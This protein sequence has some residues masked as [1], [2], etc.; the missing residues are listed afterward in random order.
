MRYLTLALLLVFV[1]GVANAQN[2]EFDPNRIREIIALRDYFD[3]AVI[4]AEPED[5]LNNWNNSDLEEI[6]GTSISPDASRLAFSSRLF[7]RVTTFSREAVCV[8]LFDTLET[9]CALPQDD[10]IEFTPMVWSHDS[11]YVA[12][13]EDNI[14]DPVET[15]IWIYDTDRNRML[16]FT[17][18][19]QSGENFDPLIATVDLAPTWNPVDNSLYFLRDTAPTGTAPIFELYRLTPEQIEA[20]FA[21]FDMQISQ[22]VANRQQDQTAATATT[23]A[24][25]AQ[26]TQEQQATQQAQATLSG[27]A[28]PPTLPPSDPAQAPSD[29]R[30][31]VVTLQLIESLQPNPPALEPQT[32][33]DTLGAGSELKSTYGETLYAPTQ[34]DNGGIFMAM[35]INN[36]NDLTQG[37]IFL[38]DLNSGATLQLLQTANIITEEPA[39]VETFELRNVRWTNDSTGLMISTRSMT[40]AADYPS[41]YFFN[42][43]TGELFPMVDYGLM[44]TERDYFSGEA[45]FLVSDSAVLA[46]DSS[47]LYF[48]RSTRSQLLSAPFPPPING[49][50][51]VAVDLGRDLNQ[52]NLLP[53]SI[54]YGEGFVRVIFDNNLITIIN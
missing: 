22:A 28:L 25:E 52:A 20:T 11:R 46:P 50:T 26:I 34:I 36:A 39:W 41:V 6:R 32:V 24:R 1:L 8:H 35:T 17:D 37:G 49:T 38:I 16:N 48:N 4:D 7:E 14:E 45:S 18:D 47:L 53:S 15:D 21:D 30:Q 40:G 23:E 42:I 51:P 12:F 33:I 27:Q 19:G 9:F 43:T 29:S 31:P 5:N 2:S 3:D 54:G 10:E 44:E 13:T